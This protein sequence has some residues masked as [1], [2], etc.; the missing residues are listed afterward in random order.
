[1]DDLDLDSSE[2]LPLIKF[3]PR[4]DRV[5]VGNKILHLESGRVETYVL[6]F[7]PLFHVRKS[8]ADSEDN[9]KLSFCDSFVAVMPHEFREHDNWKICYHLDLADDRPFSKF[10][11]EMHPSVPEIVIGH[12]P[13]V[14][15]SGPKT[16]VIQALRAQ[17]PKV[18]ASSTISRRSKH[19]YND[20]M[21]SHS[22]C[23]ISK[24]P[25]VPFDDRLLDFQL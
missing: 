5:L 8:A 7:V 11:L 18:F 19:F 10:T 21:K 13:S 16:V 12:W 25:F 24:Q 2:T 9:V 14:Y 3:S 4:L 6:P 1:M 20:Y 17:P 23:F 22:F 15:L